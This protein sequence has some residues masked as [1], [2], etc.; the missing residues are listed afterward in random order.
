M[1]IKIMALLDVF[2]YGPH[3][4]SVTF[5]MKIHILGLSIGNEFL[6]HREGN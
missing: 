2:C 4:L 6:W 3:S 1:D 5:D